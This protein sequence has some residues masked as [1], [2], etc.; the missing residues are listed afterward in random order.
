MFEPGG[1]EPPRVG[2]AREPQ[3]APAGPGG[4]AEPGPA[5][6]PAHLVS[7]RIQVES[8]DD[9]GRFRPAAA[10]RTVREGTPGS[11]AARRPERHAVRRARRDGHG[12][13]GQATEP[14]SGPDRTGPAPTTE[15]AWPGWAW[16]PWP[17]PQR[18]A[19]NT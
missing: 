5:G 6:G 15:V 9:F 2:Q 10:G 18:E 16:I 19:T 14:R 12:P 7:L 13:A 1:R 3:A 4:P 8:T 11:P 17:G